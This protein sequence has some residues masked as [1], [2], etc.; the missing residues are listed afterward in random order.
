MLIALFAMVT[1]ALFAGASLYVSV[2]EHPARMRLDDAAALAHWKPSYARATPMQAGLALISCALG[3]WAWLRAEDVWLLVAALLI[4][5][6]LPL[7]LVAIMPTNRRLQATESG[8]A[9]SRAMLASWGGRHALRT[10]L[11]LASV[12]A[13]LIA[14]LWP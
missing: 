14:F 6:N 7:T 8:G 1:A 12:A 3:I 2:A 11:G 5:A 9:E 13:Y 4:G 10:L